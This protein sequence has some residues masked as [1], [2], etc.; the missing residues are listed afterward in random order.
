MPVEPGHEFAVPEQGILR[1]QHPV[2]FVRKPEQPRIHAARLQ[3]VVVGQAVAVGHA[4]VLRAVDHERGCVHV[5]GKGGGALGQHTRQVVP[6]VGGQV[7]RTHG[8]RIGAKGGHAVKDT[9]V[10]DIG[11]VAALRRRRRHGRH[12]RRR[13]MAVHPR[14]QEAAIAATRGVNALLV[15]PGLGQQPVGAS[16]DVLQLQFTLAADEAVLEGVAEAAGAVKIHLGDNVAVA[17]EDV[18]VPAVAKGVAG[19]GVRAAVDEV[20]HGVLA[21]WIERRRKGQPHLHLL[22]QGAAHGGLF[23]VAPLHA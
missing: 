13:Q 7:F 3:R 2:V 19:S 4:V 20:G 15:G 23:H 10:A 12:G 6:V 8:V 21:F 18:C 5:A 11:A 16:F 14:H 22:T 1:L 17:G 9:G